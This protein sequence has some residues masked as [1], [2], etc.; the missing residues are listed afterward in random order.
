MG[1]DAHQGCWD[2]EMRFFSL[3]EVELI[4]NVLVSRVQQSDSVTHT[5]TYIFQILFHYSL[6][7]DTEYNSLCY[8]VGPC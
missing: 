1:T 5:Y 6:L 3:I 4:C 7:Q 8:P 2:G